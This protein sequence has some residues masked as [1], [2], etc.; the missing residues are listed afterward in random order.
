VDKNF[1]I[2][3]FKISEDKI[4]V[5]PNWIDCKEFSPSFAKR[6]N[7]LLAVGRLNKQK[8]L[9]LLFKSLE[10]TGHRLD[11]VGQGEL[12]KQLVSEAIDLGLDVKF[13]GKIPNDKMPGLYQCCKIYII[14]SDYEGNPKSLLEAMASGCAVIGTEVSGI[15]ELIKHDETGLLVNGDIKNLRDAINSLISNEKKR[16]YLA[17]NACEYVRNYHSL[18]VILKKEISMFEEISNKK[19][20][21]G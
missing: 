9:S 10:D 2:N 7:H 8:N 11:L 21:E 17:Y 1:V 13:L 19:K 20:F 3:K 12:Y 15:R 6:N 4:K 16:N 18:E 5:R 14:S